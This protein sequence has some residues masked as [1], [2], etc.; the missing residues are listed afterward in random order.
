M[1][2]GYSATSFDERFFIFV[3]LFLLFRTGTLI[4]SPRQDQDGLFVF[5]LSTGIFRLRSEAPRE[6]CISSGTNFVS[7]LRSFS[8]RLV[9]SQCIQ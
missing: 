8:H 5:L 4:P 2:L 7:C 6:A 9:G 1:W 3:P